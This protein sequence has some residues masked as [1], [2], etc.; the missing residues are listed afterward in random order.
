MSGVQIFTN[1]GLNQNNLTGDAQGETAAAGDADKSL[2]TTEFVQA[3]GLKY[4]DIITAT[5]NATLNASH[6]GKLIELQGTNPYTITLPD[7]SLFLNGSSYSFTCLTSQT[8]TIA[9]TSGQQFKTKTGIVSTTTLGNGDS[10]SFVKNSSNQW[11]VVGTSLSNTFLSGRTTGTGKFLFGNKINDVNIGN[12]WVENSGSGITGDRV[13]TMI[14]TNAV[15]KVVRVNTA[16]DPAFELQSWDDTLTTLRGYWDVA[17]VNGNLIF[18]D[19]TS[20][21]DIFLTANRSNNTLTTSKIF[22][23]SNI[24]GINT[25]DQTITLTGD[26]TGSGTGSFTVTLAN[27]GVTVGTYKSVTVDAKGRVTG[28]TNP[29]TLAGYGITDAAPLSHIS[30]T[31]LH[32]TSAQNTWIDDI[33]ATSTQVNYL[34]GVTSSIQ[35][36]LNNKQP[37]DGDLTAIAALSDTASGYLRKTGTNNWIV[38]TTMPVLATLNNGMPSYVESLGGKT[39]SIATFELNFHLNGATRNVYLKFGDGTTSSATEGIVLPNNMT[40]VGIFANFGSVGSSG[41]TVQ[42][43]VNGSTTPTD[44]LDCTVGTD[45][46]FYAAYS[47]NHASGDRIAIYGSSS[48]NWTNAFVKLIFAWRN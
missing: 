31:S 7:C 8:I 11:V 28:G 20:V 26:A 44:T 3:V 1:V 2:A 15:M 16:A 23:A 32:L 35:T 38:D 33:T 29:T 40:L 30:D 9:A 36:Q 48:N 21:D 17:V 13:F 43:R 41:V 6:L 12:A 42:V 5:G 18:R 22:S 25:G 4:G 10:V 46:S 19:R 27:S 34:V 45:V 24:S 39:I 14:D 47:S 37:I